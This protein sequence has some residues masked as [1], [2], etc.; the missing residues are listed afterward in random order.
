MILNF[1]CLKK[2]LISLKFCP[3]LIYQ[4]KY[5]YFFIGKNNGSVAGVRYFQCEAKKGVFSRLTRLSRVPLSDH[6]LEYL[7]GRQA[8]RQAA[9]IS[10]KSSLANSTSLPSERKTS[11][12]LDAA[13]KT[14]QISEPVRKV[15]PTS[16]GNKS[17]LS[18]KSGS[19]SPAGSVKKVSLP[20]AGE[21][22]K[23][24]E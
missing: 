9:N 1:I 6:D 17:P 23:L 7:A 12:G 24:Y 19:P 15:T 2:Q 16:P 13:R 18:T 3:T 20:S 21:S 10:P 4:T 5:S 11:Q 14:S 8:A 22:Q